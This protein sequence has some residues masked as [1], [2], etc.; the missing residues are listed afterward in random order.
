M[1]GS[2]KA[3]LALSG[4]G[5]TSSAGG[6]GGGGGCTALLA[7]SSV[8]GGGGG[9]GDGGKGGGMKTCAVLSIA[10]LIL[11]EVL[12]K[13]STRNNQRN[14]MDEDYYGSPGEPLAQ[15]QRQNCLQSDVLF[16]LTNCIQI[17][18]RR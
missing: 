15:T 8:M 1:G 13:F 12:I 5:G 6:G 7:T 18:M 4:G 16:K 14:N 17:S 3:T 2:G 10:T 11:I 9:G